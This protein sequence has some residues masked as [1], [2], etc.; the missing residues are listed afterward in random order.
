MRDTVPSVEIADQVK[1]ARFGR[2]FAVNPAGGGAVNAV[3]QITV[4]KFTQT[5]SAGQKLAADG[6]MFGKTGADGFFI[7]KQIRIHLNN[8][9][10]TRFAGHDIFNLRFYTFFHNYHYTTYFMV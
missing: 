8:S 4:C 10:V 7:R 2:P 5:A 1:R 9:K 3:I 6:G